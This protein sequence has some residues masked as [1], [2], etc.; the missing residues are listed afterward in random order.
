MLLLDTVQTYLELK[1]AE[2]ERFDRLEKREFKEVGDMG[3]TWAGKI[4][5][6]GWAEGSLAATR[7]L[8]IRQ[9][10]HRFGPLPE[11]VRRRMEGLD[12]QQELD[13]L[14]ERLLDV[15]SLSELGLSA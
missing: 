11:K 2:A 10:E 4:E 14:S 6:K 9:L 8:V 13:R 3:L 1:G 12:D 7:R 15:S 5:A